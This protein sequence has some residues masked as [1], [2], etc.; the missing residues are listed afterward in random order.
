VPTSAADSIAGT[1]S[2][3]TPLVRE[4]TALLATCPNFQ[5]REPQI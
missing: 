4:I 3:D 5:V 2:P 1:V